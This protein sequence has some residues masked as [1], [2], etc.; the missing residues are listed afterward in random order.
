M[1]DNWIDKE[2]EGE[3]ESDNLLPW[4]K[5]RRKESCL[6]KFDIAREV[7]IFGG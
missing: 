1:L 5:V 2:R 7:H 6:S 3:R 4:I